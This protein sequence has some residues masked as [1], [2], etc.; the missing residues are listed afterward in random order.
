MIQYRLSNQLCR[1]RWGSLDWLVDW[2]CRRIIANQ[3]LSAD[4]R[5]LTAWA[6]SCLSFIFCFCYILRPTGSFEFQEHN[7][8]FVPC[9]LLDSHQ[10]HV[11]N[12]TVDFDGF[13]W[14]HYS[15]IC[16]FLFCS[17]YSRKVKAFLLPN[18]FHPL[19]VNKSSWCFGQ[20]NPTHHNL[21]LSL[22]QMGMIPK[23]RQDYTLT[24]LSLIC[25]GQC[26]RQHNREEASI[27]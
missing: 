9:V 19:N 24:S 11:Q 25:F 1:N 22:I 27:C 10:S 15:V 18:I 7:V 13:G 8:P 16:P 26:G 21:R 3:H 2:C 17:I 6:R 23:N 20:Q 14:C 5:L 4:I 12:F